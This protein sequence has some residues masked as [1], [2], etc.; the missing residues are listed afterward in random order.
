[1][2]TLVTNGMNLLGIDSDWQMGITGLIIIIGV[3]IDRSY[4]KKKD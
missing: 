1:M 2:L 4:A 3:L